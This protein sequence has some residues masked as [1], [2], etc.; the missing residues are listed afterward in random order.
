MA[1]RKLIVVGNPFLGGAQIVTVSNR[2]ELFES[3]L[4]R[5]GDPSDL[6]PEDLAEFRE[7]FDSE[8]DMEE[9]E[10]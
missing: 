2:D 3:W 6:T 10:A 1:T 8:F 7:Y 9:A 4:S 5:L